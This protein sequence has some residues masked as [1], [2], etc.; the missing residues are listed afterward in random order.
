MTYKTHDLISTFKNWTLLVF[1]VFSSLQIQS[2]IELLDKVIA[3][4]DSGVVMESQL[5]KR[6][7]EIVDRIKESGNELPPLN[8]LEEQVLERLIIEEIQ[9]QIAERAGIKISDGELNETITAINIIKENIYNNNRSNV[10]WKIIEI[11]ETPLEKN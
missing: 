6:V 2:K 3:V 1:L 7:K 4:V 9:M 11:L 8:M 5:N 10:F